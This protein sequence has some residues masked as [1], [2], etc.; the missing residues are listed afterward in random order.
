MSASCTTDSV[1]PQWVTIGFTSTT[2]LLLIVIS[3]YS[4]Y[5]L[6]KSSLK[7]SQALISSTSTKKETKVSTHI[8]QHEHK[9]TEIKEEQEYKEE[10]NILNRQDN[11]S[12]KNELE[13][14]ELKEI[15]LI[16]EQKMDKDIISIEE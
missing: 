15:K 5:S 13:E 12:N 11:K 16:Q 10:D 4:F 7:A 2:I 3:I 8:Q 14:V 6:K 1:L 9:S